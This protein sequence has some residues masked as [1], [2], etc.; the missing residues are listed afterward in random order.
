MAVAAADDVALAWHNP[1][2]QDWWILGDVDSLQLDLRTHPDHGID[3]SGRPKR[4]RVHYFQVLYRSAGELN[5][6]Q[7]DLGEDRQGGILAYMPDHMMDSDRL[8]RNFEDNKGDNS[9][10]LEPDIPVAPVDPMVVGQR[11]LV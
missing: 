10:A 1:L 4:Y 6:G 9:R 2:R 11:M 5:Q 7:L 8:D 3:G